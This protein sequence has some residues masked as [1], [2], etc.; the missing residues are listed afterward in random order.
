MWCVRVDAGKRNE[1]TFGY[2][3]AL[4]INSS[5]KD[6]KYLI[7]FRFYAILVIHPTYHYETLTNSTYL[8]SMWKRFMFLEF[9]FVVNWFSSSWLR[10]QRNQQNQNLER[11]KISVNE[12]YIRSV[13]IHPRFTFKSNSISLVFTL[14]FLSSFDVITS[15]SY[16]NKC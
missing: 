2:C 16:I 11:F 14:F 8:W 6:D 12:K 10:F 5:Q 9:N 7:E 15:S 4:L 13:F 1:S 3:A